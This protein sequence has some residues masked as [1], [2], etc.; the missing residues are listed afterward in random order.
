M[1]S[2]VKFNRV[3]QKIQGSGEGSGEGRLWCRARSG[4][5]GFRRR[6]R[7]RSAGALV[8]GARSG[9]TGSGEGTGER[10]V[11]SQ[12]RFTRVPGSFG[13]DRAE[14]FPALGLTAR[15][16][17]ICKNKRLRLLGIS[18]KLICSRK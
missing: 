2:R 12:I 3:P 8:Q 7:R 13:A 6:F 16:G 5:T 4:S 10:L 18:P 1:Q 15:C 11:Q 9:S 17:K 14:I